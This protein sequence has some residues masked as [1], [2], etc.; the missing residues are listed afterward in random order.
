MQHHMAM[1]HVQ[2][3]LQQAQSPDVNF[4][5]LSGAG[6]ATAA[7]RAS[8]LWTGWAFTVS[9]VSTGDA[10]TRDESFDRPWRAREPRGEVAGIK[11][12]A[13]K[14]INVL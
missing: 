5:F 6:A 11:Y 2:M 4:P 7:T 13:Q 1:Q 14:V 3:W 12:C 8:V 9:C 10:S